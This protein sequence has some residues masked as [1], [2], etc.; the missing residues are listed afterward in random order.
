MA[1]L[2]DDMQPARRIERILVKTA[3]RIYFVRT[4]EIDWIE[5]AGNYVRLHVGGARHLLRQTMSALEDQLD[6]N[7][8]LRIHRSTIVNVDRVK[9]LNRMFNGEYEVRLHDGTKL[10]LSRGYRS[11]LDR[12]SV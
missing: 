1:H 2:L 12:F 7:R 5:A 3:Q 6:P 9:E 4:D 8:F 11:Q 10:T